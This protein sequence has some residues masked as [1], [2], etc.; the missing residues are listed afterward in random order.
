MRRARAAL[1]GMLVVVT[2][3]VAPAHAAG[4]APKGSVG[5]DVSYPQCG[6]VGPSM[7]AAF[8]VVGVTGGTAWSANPCLA[9]EAARFP[10]ALH[11][12]VN[13]GW[14]SASTHV[15]ATT[16]RKCASGDL[17]CRA[18]NYGYGAGLDALSVAAAAGVH[19]STWWLDVENGN[20]WST[21]TAQN[22]ASLQGEY[23]ALRT[24]GVAVVGAYSTTTQWNAITGSWLNGWPGWGATVLTSATEA[25]TY[26]TG[27]RFTGGQTW[28]IQFTGATYDEDVTCAVAAVPGAPRSVSAS[29]R[30]RSAVVSWAA[31]ASTGG[32]AITGYRVTASPGGRSCATTTA[33]TCTV[34]GLVDRT[35]Y[36][37]TVRATTIAGVGPVSLPSAA[38]VSGAPSAVRSLAVVFPAAHVVRATW[39][40][41]VS[42]GSGAVTAYQVRWTSDAGLHWTSWAS[43]RLTRAASRNG[44]VKGRTCT[45]QVRAL[46]AY[47]A[48]PVAGRT[49]VQGR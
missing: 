36:R 14:Y 23:D 33:R 21:V 7:T 28:M 19:G 47:G 37:F 25:A 27:H 12:Y 3:L 20:T 45:V 9:A 1:L 38:V 13:S 18:Y 16:P 30:S 42:R 29:P 11:L 43:T 22:R 6:A 10:S 34:T 40:T 5:I 8:G 39:L 41:P 15:S 24:G 31:P 48:G 26:C 2:T 44:L 35:A 49:F 32:S 17:V 4:V 46:N